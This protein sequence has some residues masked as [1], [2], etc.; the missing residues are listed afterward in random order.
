M[1]VDFSGVTVVSL[2]G[3]Q[4][5]KDQTMMY[6]TYIFAVKSCVMVGYQHSSRVSYI[7]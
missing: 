6:F 4:K 7:A 3:Q 2:D 5:V 1:K